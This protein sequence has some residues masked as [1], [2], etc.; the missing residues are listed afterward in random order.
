[1]MVSGER[2]GQYPQFAMLPLERL[3]SHVSRLTSHVSSS[4]RVLLMTSPKVILNREMPTIGIP[5][6][7]ALFS[8]TST[9]WLAYETDTKGSFAVIRFSDVFDHRLSPI[10]DE[11]LGEH[12]YAKFGLNFY[13]FH[14]IENSLETQKWAMLSVHHWVLTFKDNAL[15]VLA[16]FIEIMAANVKA[17]NPTD[18]LLRLLSTAD[19]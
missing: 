4:V 13:S 2:L 9:L 7:P 19:A 14:E 3:T 5:E 11:G 12:P 1:M 16:C 6:P 15:D 10:N 18:A 8:D 17:K